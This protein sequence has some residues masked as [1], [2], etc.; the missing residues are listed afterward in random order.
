MI[1]ERKR[2]MIMAKEIKVLKAEKFAQV[3]A[4]LEEQEKTELVEFIQAELDR[5]NARQA[6]AKERAA[7]KRAASDVLV[8]VVMQAVENLGKKATRD[9]VTAEVEA[10]YDGEI[11]IT[12]NKVGARLTKLV[13][14]G[15]VAKEA[16]TINK[17]RKMVYCVADATADEV[18][19]EAE[20]D[21]I[22]E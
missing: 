16:K 22:E 17:S 5:H 10:I 14:A 19:V 11:E 3:I 20:E 12:P 1:K 8:D 15:K 21:V 6:K 2:E 18:E 9:E 4:V 13:E 7:K